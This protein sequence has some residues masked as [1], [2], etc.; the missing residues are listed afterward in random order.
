MNIMACKTTG[1][2]TACSMVEIKE[3]STLLPL[4]WGNP[5]VTG[6]FPSQRAYTSPLWGESAGN[7]ENVSMSW[8]QQTEQQNTG[9]FNTIKGLPEAPHPHTTCDWITNPPNLGYNYT[10]M[11]CTAQLGGPVLKAFGRVQYPPLQLA[12]KSP[13]IT[14]QHTTGGSVSQLSQLAKSWVYIISLTQWNKIWAFMVKNCAFMAK[15]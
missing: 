7:A 11:V 2:T 9:D 10:S 14:D 6:G 5:T 13:M 15:K 4:L 12:D 1:N 8:R 3:T